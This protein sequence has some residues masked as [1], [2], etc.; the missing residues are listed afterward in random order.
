[1]EF[2]RPIFLAVF[3]LFSASGVY[4]ADKVDLNKATASQLE[5]IKGIG[6]KLAGAIIKY[7]KEHHGFKS[8]D[9]L[10]S[11]KGIG[12]KNFNR[13]KSQLILGGDSS[14]GAHLS[15]KSTN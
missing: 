14:K 8:L 10:K 4:A 2:M 12:D 6:P 9:E 13:F 7:R 1:M 3:L 11:V 5:T 15:K